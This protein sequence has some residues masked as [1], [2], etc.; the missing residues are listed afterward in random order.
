[1]GVGRRSNIWGSWRQSMSLVAGVSRSGPA[2]AYGDWRR[3]AL[4]DWNLAASGSQ[5]CAKT[6][7]T[8][9][10]VFRHYTTADTTGHTRTG[11]EQEQS[12]E[13]RPP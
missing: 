1:M 4:S 9:P 2:A 3:R 11:Q 7:P 13:S 6:T 5:A 10:Q 12:A 8:V